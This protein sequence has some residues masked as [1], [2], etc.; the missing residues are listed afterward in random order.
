MPLDPA[1]IE[2]Y[3]KSG[4]LAAEALEY[5]SG[6]IKEG[7]LLLDVA[8]KIE[9]FI[10]SKGGKPAFPVNIAI[11]SVAAHFSPFHDS[12]DVFAKGELAKL[13]VGVH[14]DGY[15]GDTARTVEVGTKNQSQLIKASEE[16]LEAVIEMMKPKT[17][18]ETIGAAVENTINSFGYEP[19]ANLSG[20]GLAQYALHTGVSVP[21]VPENSCEF[22]AEGAVLA[23]E[24]FATDGAGSVVEGTPSSIYR[25]VRTED[26][27]MTGKPGFLSRIL[28]KGGN[29]DETGKF[30]D[31]IRYEY[32][33]LPF[34]ERWC[35][36]IDR[37]ARQKLQALSKYK[38]ISC[39]PM[40]K[41]AGGG[42]VSQSEHTVL[43]TADG[44]EVLTRR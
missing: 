14:F 38:V 26:A 31:L 8:D 7:A 4:R 11:D 29:V 9:D 40:L 21:N 17:R 6:L 13:D 19:I 41:E 27:S 43:V 23:I 39:Y 3:R 12:K 20:H 36:S 42:I 16:A 18:M 22:V 1:I 32:R 10:R 5:G 35:N 44:C 37:N 25:L 34:S 28:G 24:P 33:T 15:I 2:K 30:L